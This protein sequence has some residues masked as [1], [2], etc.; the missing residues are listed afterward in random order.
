MAAQLEEVVVNADLFEPE[1]SPPD[2]GERF[3]GRSAR[4]HEIPIRFLFAVFGDRQCVAVELAVRV[5]RQRVEADKRGR[6]HI[7]GQPLCQVTTQCARHQFV[8]AV[9]DEISNQAL[10]ARRVF[11]SHDN[12]FA[13]QWEVA[14]RCFNLA[15]FDTETTQ[16]YLMIDT[17]KKFQ[18]PVGPEARQV[19]RSVKTSSRLQRKPIRNIGRRCPHRI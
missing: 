3:F 13:H 10:L 8:T 1:R 5:Q 2:I 7:V 11:P 19:T 9:A 6:N 18:I 17:P 15:E 4:G 12:T 16:L 14:E